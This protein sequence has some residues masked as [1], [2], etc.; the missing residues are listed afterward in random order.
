MAFG[1]EMLNDSGSEVLGPKF[2]ALVYKSKGSV[3]TNTA[4]SLGGSRYSASIAAATTV[5]LIALRCDTYGCALRR[6][7]RINASSWT[8]EVLCSGPVGTTIH[9]YIFDLITNIPPT[10]PGSWGYEFF[11]EGANLTASSG[12]KTAGCPAVVNA[13]DMINLL[14][15]QVQ[16]PTNY[17]DVALKAGRVYSHWTGKVIGGT[18]PNGPGEPRDIWTFNGRNLGNGYRIANQF[19]SEV[20]TGTQALAGGQVVILDVTDL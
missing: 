12:Y 6:M 19:M 10:Q 8:F 2:P 1:L 17:A 18:S 9:Y 3:V 15:G 14:G 7:V 13:R 4:L 5:P 16:Q 20:T 11:D